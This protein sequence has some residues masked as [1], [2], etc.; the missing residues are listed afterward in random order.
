MQNLTLLKKL[1]IDVYYSVIIRGFLGVWLRHFC[2]VRSKLIYFRYFNYLISI[3]NCFQTISYHL[4]NCKHTPIKV[5]H[6]H[7]WITARITVTKYI[8]PYTQ[9]NACICFQTMFLETSPNIHHNESLP[10]SHFCCINKVNKKKK[11]KI[12]GFK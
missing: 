11:R 7:Y 2:R 6:K 1:S 10:P 12:Y 8:R 3:L 5:K 4:K 9:K